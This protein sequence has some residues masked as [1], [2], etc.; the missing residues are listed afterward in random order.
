MVTSFHDILLD[1]IVSSKGC[2]GLDLLKIGFTLI[3]ILALMSTGPSTR[4]ET[5]NKEMPNLN[6]HM[7]AG[8]LVDLRM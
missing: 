5:Y 3:T 6:L 7:H 2:H 1:C 8:V 4:P